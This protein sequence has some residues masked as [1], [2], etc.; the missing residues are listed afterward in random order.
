MSSFLNLV[1]HFLSVFLFWDENTVDILTCKVKANSNK[2]FFL[3]NSRRTRARINILNITL[4]KTPL[5]FGK[6]KCQ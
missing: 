4:E 6:M 1:I 3:I 5:V 2:I